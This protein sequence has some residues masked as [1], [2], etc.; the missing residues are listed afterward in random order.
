M[1]RVWWRDSLGRASTWAGF[2]SLR[3]H[4][5]WGK[6]HIFQLP[7]SP[8]QNE[9]MGDN[10]QCDPRSSCL[11]SKHSFMNPHCRVL[12]GGPGWCPSCCA[13]LYRMFVV[14]GSSTSRVTA[15][16]GGRQRT[17]PRTRQAAEPLQ[18]ALRRYCSPLEALNSN[19]TPSVSQPATCGPSKKDRALKENILVSKCRL[20]RL[21]NF[22]RRCTCGQGKKGR[23]PAALTGVVDNSLGPN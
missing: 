7:L 19:R 20:I 23:S 18:I 4:A 1:G 22:L 14:L 17:Y 12:G 9:V 10:H 6:S 3:C 2:E 8:P 16:M 5:V 15:E 21:L 13:L 11:L